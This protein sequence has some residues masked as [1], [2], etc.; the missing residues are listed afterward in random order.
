[1]PPAVVA[2]DRRIEKALQN[3]VR[4][5]R[6]AGAG[7]AD[8]LIIRC[9]AGNLSIAAPTVRGGTM[10]TRMP[11]DC[12]V[13]LSALKLA[14]LN[15]EI[16]ISRSRPG[17]RTETLAITKAM[18]DIYNL[19]GKVAQHRRTSPWSLIAAHPELL[20]YIAPPSR[21]DFPF[22]AQDIRAGH[23][24]KIVLASF[25]HSRLFAHNPSGQGRSR[26]VLVPITDFLNHH[27][28][29]EPYSY[30]SR[31]AVVMRCSA[32]LRENDDEC[33]ASYGLHDAHDTW[34]TYGFVD[35]DVP[36]VQSLA[37]TVDLS[38]VG[39]IRFG[40][41]PLAQREAAGLSVQSLQSY[42]PR[43]LRRNGNRVSVAAAVIPGPQAPRALRRALRLLIG[44]LGA[45]RRQQ[46]QLVM[47]AEEQI[48][49]ANLTY[50]GE[51][52]SCLQSLSV[53][54]ATHSAIRD[55][56]LRLCEGQV[57]RLRKYPNY[58]AG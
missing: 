54:S 7:L 16:V 18:F 31:G 50:Y 10:L 45:P 49:E 35:A 2:D 17:L 58:A 20:S 36:F 56:F 38:G 46:N 40:E 30:G 47:R 27:W 42:V 12:L 33:F 14:L 24:A 19:A 23:D 21:D 29:G 26:P 1:M 13:P 4:L 32:P 44:E 37:T 3:L 9:I 28:K 6:D 5:L 51:L 57:A 8:G 11:V 15:D 39:T 48:L 55:N 53:E 25:L 52:K 43:V 41:V 34:I 22:S